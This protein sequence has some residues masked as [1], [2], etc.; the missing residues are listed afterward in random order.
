MRLLRRNGCS[1]VGTRS[2]A[3]V[4]SPQR[5]G[6]GGTRP[7]Q[8]LVARCETFGLA[9]LVCMVP[10]FGLRA[11]VSNPTSPRTDAVI[12]VTNL[13]PPPPAARPP[14]AIFKQ[15]LD[16]SPA[17][18]MVSLSNRPP[19]IRARILA[20]LREYEALKQDERDLKLKATELRWRMTQLINTPSTNR[21]AL[22]ADVP[23]DDRKFIE[24]RLQQWD[25]LP[26]DLQKGILENQALMNYFMDQQGPRAVPPEILP[27]GFHPELQ[28]GIA[29]W[30]AMSESE[31]A[32]VKSRFEAFFGLNEQEKANAL[33]SLS[34]AERVQIQNTLRDFGNLTPEQRSRCVRSFD[35]FATMTVEERRRVLRNAEE[36][37]RMTPSQRQSFRQ[38]VSRLAMEPPPPPGQGSPPG[39]PPPPTPGLPAPRVVTNGN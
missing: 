2:T 26:P 8:M 20:K 27:P 1:W 31:R 30:Q 32:A 7:Y 5:V 19:E 22:L 37:S 6:R 35:Q 14:V 18:R 39:P 9:V 29:R 38:L 17:Q 11:Q 13:P 33:K 21:S 3:S 25:L 10:A 12:S 24:A 23:A 28:P 15:L 4:T 36:W 16:M 34:D